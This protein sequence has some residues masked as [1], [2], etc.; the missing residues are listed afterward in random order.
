MQAVNEFV[1]NPEG[2]IRYYG[3]SDH[4]HFYHVKD[5]LGNIRETYIHP[6]AG[7]KECMERT[8]YYP[9]GLPWVERY[10]NSEGTHPWKYNGKVFIEMHGLDEYDSKARWY[11]PAIC[12]TTTMD[13]LAEKYYPTSPY[14]WCGNNPV[15]N[16]DLDGMDVWELDANGE[17]THHREYNQCDSIYV[18]NSFGET[19]GQRYEYGTIKDMLTNHKLAIEKEDKIYPISL[20]LWNIATEESAKTIFEFFADNTDVEWSWINAT[21]SGLPQYFLTT[22]H[23]KDREAG[24]DYLFKRGVTI[25]QHTHSHPYKPEPSTADKSWANKLLQYN[26]NAVLQIYYCLNYYQ[27][28]QDGFKITH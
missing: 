4:Y 26:P 19:L 15:K 28:D 9:S 22:I 3:A 14:A 1:H 20:D 8:Q 6:E 27:Y 21:E 16:V 25:H 5:L 13:P 2:F 12:R 18:T 24:P 11:Y 23:Q 17:M 10:S 7:Y